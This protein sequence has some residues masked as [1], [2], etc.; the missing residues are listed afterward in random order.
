MQD[1]H[2]KTKETDITLFLVITFVVATALLVAKVAGDFTKT[3]TSVSTRAAKNATAA[4]YR[5]FCLGKIESN[6]GKKYNTSAVQSTV[7]A[8]LYETDCGSLNNRFAAGILSAGSGLKQ[9]V[10]PGICCVALSALYVV[11]DNLC[12]LKMPSGHWPDG[13]TVEHIPSVCKDK[14]DCSG[15]YGTINTSNYTI[16]TSSK[17]DNVTTTSVKN[18]KNYCCM[19]PLPTNTP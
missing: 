12:T 9:T 17:C 14:A 18:D 19:M 8:K 7:F 2:I 5:P 4:D 6:L 10:E 1:K 13:K 16:R 15:S 3:T 11:N